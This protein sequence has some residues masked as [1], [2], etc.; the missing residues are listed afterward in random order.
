MNAQTKGNE[1]A[2]QVMK[3]IDFVEYQKGAVV[4]WT[5]VD[6][7]EGTITAS[8]FGAGQGLRNPLLDL[9]PLCTWF[10]GTRR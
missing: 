8:A 5:F 1:R 9:M 3:V 7:K 4:R 2:T 10:T 6:K